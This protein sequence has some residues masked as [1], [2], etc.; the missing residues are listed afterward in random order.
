LF[1]DIVEFPPATAAAR[2]RR[3]GT[4]VAERVISASAPVVQLLAPNGGEQLGVDTEVRWQASDPDGDALT[5]TLMYSADGGASWSPIATDLRGAGATLP[6]DA[7]LTGSDRALLRVIASDG[8][9]IASD[10]SDAPFAVP[11]N[12]PSPSIAAPVDGAVLA[13]GGTALL[14]GAAFDL[15]D[16][17]VEDDALRWQSSIDGDLGAGS[18]LPV[19]TLSRGE[20]TITLTAIDSSGTVA[21][22]EIR[23]SVGEPRYAGVPEQDDHEAIGRV[24]T[25]S[26]DNGGGDGRWIAFAGA[27][28]AAA[29]A[30]AG[31]FM[32]ARSR[33]RRR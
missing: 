21:E 9:R 2:V 6:A 16:G 7:G 1:A 11:N 26:D 24:L 4:V 18:Q 15:E 25:G 14:I 29:A 13:E 8:M 28:A 23:V 5:F 22:R 33:L 19:R 31:G 3:G 10:D 32:L 30:S 20:H 12:P 27:A 17:A